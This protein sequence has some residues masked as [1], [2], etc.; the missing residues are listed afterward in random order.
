MWW[1]ARVY[2]PHAAVASLAMDRLCRHV[3]TRWLWAVDASGYAT[4]LDYRSAGRRRAH[5]HPSPRS[6][7]D[8]ARCDGASRRDAIHG[9]P[10]GSLV[11]L[12]ER[13]RS[14]RRRVRSPRRTAV[15]PASGDGPV[16]VRTRRLPWARRARP[17]RARRGGHGGGRS[18]VRQARAACTLPGGQRTSHALKTVCA[19]GPWR[20][21]YCN[22]VGRPT[23][24]RSG[25]SAPAGRRDR[26]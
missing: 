2:L 10:A 20:R 21:R 9:F 8:A 1:S 19:R 4:F 13:R 15:S 14:Y 7:G 22:C 17:H 5:P 16:P 11:F 26:A 6:A 24:S 25:T 23:G 12:R 3:G 18:G